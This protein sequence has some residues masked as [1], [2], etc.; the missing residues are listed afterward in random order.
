MTCFSDLRPRWELTKLKK[1]D[2]SII[3]DTKNAEFTAHKDIWQS[4]VELC[5][6]VLLDLLG[7][8]VRV[9]AAA[10]G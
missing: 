1:K 6:D 4:S 8:Q 9:K 10:A 3:S 2:V 5:A 7:L